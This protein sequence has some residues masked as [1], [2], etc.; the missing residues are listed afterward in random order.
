MA[1]GGHVNLDITAGAIIL[2]Q[3]FLEL[4]LNKITLSNFALRE[5]IILDTINKERGSEQ[6]DFCACMVYHRHQYCINHLG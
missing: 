1:K 3:I 6:L 5:G 4:D 2:E